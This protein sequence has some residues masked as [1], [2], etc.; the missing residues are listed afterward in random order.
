MR[1]RFLLLG[2]VIGCL[3]V[4]CGKD[5]ITSSTSNNKE[6][7]KVTTDNKVK[8][9]KFDESKLKIELNGQSIKL[10]CKVD[11]LT[12]IGYKFVNSDEDAVIKPGELSESIVLISADT[13]DNV[14]II[15]SNNSSTNLKVSQCEVS[16]I[17]LSNLIGKNEGF[18]INGVGFTNTYEEVVNAIGTPTD[19]YD[20]YIGEDCIEYFL[21]DNS[22]VIITFRDNTI[23][24]VNYQ[25][26]L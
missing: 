13:D 1:K 20:N 16:S 12:N 21:K 10:P 7:I 11:V 26:S 15:V 22:K 3:L 25:F 4:G 14:M 6:S 23:K 19:T 9:T 5:N 2:V 8:G 18:N 24:K 17:E